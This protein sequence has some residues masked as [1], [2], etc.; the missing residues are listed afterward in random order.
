MPTS[1]LTGL[2]NEV[3]PSIDGV[4]DGYDGNRRYSLV[5]SR[6]YNRKIYQSGT[7]ASTQRL[8]I[9]A[10][11]VAP[12]ATPGTGGN[13]YYRYVYVNKRFRDVYAAEADD[14]FI[15]SNASPI[16]TVASVSTSATAITPTLSADTQVTHLWLYV[17]SSPTDTF[18]RLATNYEV[19]N[20]GTPT[21]T[22]VT[23][24]PI[25]SY[26]LETDNDPPDTCRIVCEAGG[27]YLYG[28]FVPISTTASATIGSNVVTGTGFPDGIESLFLQFSGD[29]SGGVSNNGVHLVKY[30]DSST[31]N[32]IDSS[33]TARNYDGPSNK[34]GATVRIWRSA[35][36]IQISKKYNQDFSP[37]LMDDNFILRG[38]G[39]LTCLAKPNSGQVVRAHW[40]DQGKKAIWVIDFTQGIPARI[41]P[42]AS[43][44]CAANPRAYA[45][46]GSRMFYYDKD[47]GVI[48]DRG[49][50]HVPV[51]LTVIPNLIRSLNNSTEDIAEME[52]DESRNLLFLSCAPTGYD[53]AYYLIVYNLTT[54]TWNLW[55][56]LPDVLSMRRFKDTTTG[57]VVVRMGSSN[58][59]IMDWPSTN[60]NEGVG[61]SIYGNV[62]SNDD[63]THLTAIT[64]TF[65]TTGY[66]LED[67]WVMVW[68]DTAD[69]P[70]YQFARIASNT[71]SRLTLDT[72]IGPNSTTGFDPLPQTGWAYW[73]GP[74]QSILGPNFDFNSTPDDDGKLLDV[75]V[76]TSGLGAQANSRVSF[77]RNFETTPDSGASM[78]HNRYSDNTFDPDHQTVKVANLADIE[79]TGVTGWQFVD[80]N[81]AP[82]SVKAI[83]RRV[84][85][86]NEAL[87]AQAVRK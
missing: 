74:I 29:T 11:T 35:A 13:L 82:L 17:A 33:G 5:N 27:F 70:V 75:S 2:S 9:A 32:L 39:A 71:A 76:T 30:V 45:A 52:Y 12:T 36:A 46:V 51:T 72:F 16:L 69:L 57:N 10:P 21:W 83:V 61:S 84:R 26:I 77:Y 41:F 54:N 34:V 19:A 78:A 25:A 14:Y 6:N 50:V 49:Q 58:G 43:A 37:Y 66:S 56:M 18:Y 24:V 31:L 3:K 81:E 80:N 15:R 38:P 47:A 48:E 44:Y 65:P 42:V 63:A 4:P 79:A 8:G 53:K 1:F 22:G 73:V 40:N 59:S 60:F 23:T 86:V 20:S 68:D 64:G 62:A 85:A 87:N 7:G 67:R 28:G 55:F